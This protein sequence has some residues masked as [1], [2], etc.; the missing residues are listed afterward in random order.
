MANKKVSR[1]ARSP[2]IVGVGCTPFGSVLDTPGIQGMGT[3]DLV[4]AAAKEAMADAGLRPTD[5]D[6]FFIGGMQSHTSHV[7]SHYSR[8]SDWIG[9]QFKPGLHFTTACSTTNTGMGLGA[10]AVASGRFDT[11]IVVAVETLLSEPAKNPTER[12]P[13]DPAMLWFWT[14]FGVDQVYAYPHGYDILTAYGAL[15]ALAY[16]KKFG[17]SHQ[18]L[19]RVFM[20]LATAVRRHASLNPKAVVKTDVPTEAKDKGYSS[21][22]EFWKS[23]RHNPYAAWP[24]RLMNILSPAD[25]ASA[26][27][28]TA[29][30]VAK[31]APN[32]P[33]EILGFEWSVSN[34]PWYEDPS[35]WPQDKKAFDGAYEMADV[36]GSDI[37]Y[38][39]IHDCMQ[40]YHLL[41]SELSGYVGEGQAWRA[42][43]DGRFMFDGDRPM[44]TS[45]GRHGMGHA[46]GASAG[47]DVYE[48]VKQMRGQAGPRQI[49]SPPRVAA[50]H[51]H[52]YGMHSSVTVLGRR[53]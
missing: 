7:Y 1:L 23:P 47:A 37:E 26:Y 40:S 15:P 50:V 19:E 51:N 39:H 41:L 27:V 10:M 25:G 18:D 3:Q 45:G 48:T 9:M 5:I 11:V 22:E 35:F 17:L 12:T 13:V 52:G 33:I 8:L 44:N 21:V 32:P 4:V 2:S 14:D 49:K 30:D 34:F 31:G 53:G 24:L 43:L 20:H 38:L 46:F 6:A 29:A 16:G 28:I 42:A 36:K